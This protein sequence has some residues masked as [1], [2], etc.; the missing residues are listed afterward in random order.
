MATA[1]VRPG[2]L[3]HNA[4]G[5]GLFTGGLGF[6]HGAERLGATVL[7]V[8]SGQTRRQAMLL[9]DLQA[10]VLT[11]T[12]SYALTIAEALEEAGI[13][14]D[15]LALE[16]G[17]FG[18]EPW[19]ESMREQLERRLGLRARNFYGLSEI[20]GPGVAAECDEAAGAH[21]NEDH[22]LVEVVDGELV[23][24][25]LTKE[26]LPLIRYRTGDI[27]DGRRVAVR[28]RAHAR[29]H[30]PGARPPRRHAD[31][32]RRQRLPVRDRA[33]AARRR[34]RRAALRADGR[35]PRG[36]RR[37]PRPL[38]GARRQRRPRA[39]VHEALR[40]R[41]GIG[42]EVELVETGTLPRSQGKAARVIDKR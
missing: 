4:Y 5:Y 34:R 20:I 19:S 11:C 13:G 27:A 1:G 25:T 6:H 23:I 22:F 35:A 32:A 38:R 15:D 31:P 36:E 26:A 2:M 41:T 21:L 14:P 29:T 28:V 37:G 30:G 40:E 39:R 16:V 7:P 17:L 9:R 33:R 18:A 42:I 12:P 10:Q 24:T 8:S 3:V